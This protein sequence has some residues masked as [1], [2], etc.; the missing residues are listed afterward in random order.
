MLT[1][2][3]I[4]MVHKFSRQWWL[5]MQS[6]VSNIRIVGFGSRIAYVSHNRVTYD[7]CRI[8]RRRRYEDKER[9]KTDLEEKRKNEIDE[10][11]IK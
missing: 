3:G 9:T 10:N 11:T 7:T 1:P 4:I 2:Y 6:L 5:W 8:R